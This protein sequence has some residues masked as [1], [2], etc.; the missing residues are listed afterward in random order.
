MTPPRSSPT[1]Q[2][3]VLAVLSIAATHLDPCLFA[4][5]PTEV[6]VVRPK[7]GDL[8]RYVALPGTLRANQQVTVQARVGGFIRAIHVDRGDRVAAGQLL[9]EVEV[10]ELLAQSIKD[11]AEVRVAEA[12]H[13]RLEAARQ[14]SPDLVTPQSVDAARGRWEVARAQQR[15][16]EIL[17]GYARIT[18]PFAG[19]VSDRFVDHGAFVPAGRDGT[20]S[21]IV[22]MVDSMVLRV[23]V[24]V[25]EA[26]AVFIQTGQP[27]RVSVEGLPTETFPVT[28]SRNAGVLDDASRTLLVEADLPN[29]SG[30]LRPGMFATARIGLEEHRGTLLIP[31]EAV[32]TEKASS[33]VFVIQD[34]RIRKTAVKA[35]FQDPPWVEILSGINESAV[36]VTPAKTAPPDG[37]PVQAREAR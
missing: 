5:G 35:G 11:T 15:Q 16:T 29:P 14:K 31:G 36:L 24:P 33:F 9:A 22:R 3:I 20:A 34:G 18:A 4:A 7:R 13:R 27:I 17:L 6:Q 25:P 1:P 26:E 37:T 32:T 10:P 21:A 12:E 30:R 28:V 8:H 19:T 23:Q 2:R